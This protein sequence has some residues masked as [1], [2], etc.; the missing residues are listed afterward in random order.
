M[1]QVCLMTDGVLL[2]TRVDRGYQDSGVNRDQ[3]RSVIEVSDSYYA[4]L[5]SGTRLPCPGGSL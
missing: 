2:I 5:S 4:T 3:H 1:Q